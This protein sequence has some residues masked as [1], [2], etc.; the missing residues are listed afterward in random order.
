MDPFNLYNFNN[1]TQWSRALTGGGREVVLG[2]HPS[3]NGAMGKLLQL[4][5]ELDVKYVFN[6]CSLAN[7]QKMQLGSCR[8]GLLAPMSVLFPPY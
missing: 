1:L 6:K 8:V 4:S 2:R 7:N 5:V 3:S